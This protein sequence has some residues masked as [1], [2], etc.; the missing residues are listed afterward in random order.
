MSREVPGPKNGGLAAR[1]YVACGPPTDWRAISKSML[2]ELRSRWICST[3]SMHCERSP[4]PRTSDKGKST[5]ACTCSKIATRDRTSRTHLSS[6]SM[7]NR[8]GEFKR[9]GG[10]EIHQTRRRLT[11]S[12]SPDA[13]LCVR[14]VQK[15]WSRFISDAHAVYNSMS[16]GHGK[17]RPFD[18]FSTATP[19]CQELLC[20]HRLRRGTWVGSRSRMERSACSSPAGCWQ[21]RV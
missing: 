15:L 7:W 3:R 19:H 21:V 8:S 2:L 12:L 10:L 14:T 4:N 9:R 13:P 6:V 18:I 20:G 1:R 17:K 16:G 11:E 5:T